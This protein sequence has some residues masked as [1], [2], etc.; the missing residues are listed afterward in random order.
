MIPTGLQGIRKRYAP[1]SVIT[2]I[3][4]GCIAKEQR[5]INTNIGMLKYLTDYAD[6][7]TELKYKDQARH[8]KR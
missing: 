1:L 2:S 6:T 5:Y 8:F 3:Y 4:K 7:N